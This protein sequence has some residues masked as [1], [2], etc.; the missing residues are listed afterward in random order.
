MENGTQKKNEK[1]NKGMK[2]GTGNGT[3]SR[4]E[5]VTLKGDPNWNVKKNAK[6]CSYGPSIV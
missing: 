1:P 6:M 3:R 4:I 5:K 2:T